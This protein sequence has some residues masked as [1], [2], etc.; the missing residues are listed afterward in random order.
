M[1]EGSGRDS[2]AHMVVPIMCDELEAPA[3]PRLSCR[4]KSLAVKEVLQEVRIHK[5]DFSP[6]ESGE[7]TGSGSGVAD[8]A[9]ILV[10]Y[11]YRMSLCVNCRG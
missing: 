11:N 9:P 7:R 2:R 8:D 4:C 5:Y 10:D 6:R 3:R 1:L